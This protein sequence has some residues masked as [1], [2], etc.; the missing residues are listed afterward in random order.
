[1]MAERTLADIPDSELLSRVVAH[2]IKSR[3]K[4]RPAWAA[5][6]D[7]FCLGSSFSAQ[8]C[9]RFGYDSDTGKKEEL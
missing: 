8:L 6:Y 9:Q 2:L 3:H 1:M 4:S 5:I 7:A